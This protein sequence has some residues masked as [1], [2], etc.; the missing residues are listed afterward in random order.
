MRYHR[1]PNKSRLEGLIPRIALKPSTIARPSWHDPDRVAKVTLWFVKLGAEDEAA[2][3]RAIGLL[4]LIDRKILACEKELAEEIKRFEDTPTHLD[5]R[6]GTV[7]ITEQQRSDR[8]ET[9]F[10]EFLRNWNLL[11]C[12]IEDMEEEVSRPQ[13]ELNEE[14]VRYLERK[15]REGFSKA[16]LSSLR[17]I[18]KVT[19]GIRSG[20]KKFRRRSRSHCGSG[21]GGPLMSESPE[22]S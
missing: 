6:R 20:A 9:N 10:I 13:R 18:F 17:A 22:N 12:P 2:V 15:K 11:V 1:I 21:C 4:K 16:E 7:F 19:A 8:A 3:D 5:F 14:Q